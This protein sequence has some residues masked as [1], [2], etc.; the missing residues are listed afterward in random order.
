MSLQNDRAAF[1]IK[2]SCLE[3]MLLAR[4]CIPLRFSKNIRHSGIG[5]RIPGN[6]E[7]LVLILPLF[8]FFM[9]SGTV[10]LLQYRSG[11]SAM[12]LTSKI[13]PPCLPFSMTKLLV[14]FAEYRFPETPQSMGSR[15]SFLYRLFYLEKK[16]RWRV[17]CSLALPFVLP[18]PWGCTETLLSLAFQLVRQ[19]LEDAYGGILSIWMA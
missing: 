15:R 7:N 18:K 9:P 19:R 12:S 14:G 13:G 17:A 10:A 11:R 3:C 8:H 5:T 1:C 2:D 6:L 16:S 4:W